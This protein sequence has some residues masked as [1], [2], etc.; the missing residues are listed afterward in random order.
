MKKKE[1][2][3]IKSTFE[4]MEKRNNNKRIIYNITALVLLRALRE[5]E[6]NGDQE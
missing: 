5:E 1:R 4:R 2:N 3:K 6:Q